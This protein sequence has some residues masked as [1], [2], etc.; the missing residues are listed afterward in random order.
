MRPECFGV[1]FYDE[2]GVECPHH[3]CLLRDECVKTH[4]SAMGLF[5]EKKLKRDQQEA[6]GEKLKRVYKKQRDAFFN[7][8]IERGN[9][10]PKQKKGY[11]KPARLL[12]QDEGYPKDAYIFEIRDCDT[13]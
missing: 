7:S 1:E 10:F 2:S 8:V 9:Q 12:Y 13:R 6:Q 11:K 5:A 4:Q 3:E